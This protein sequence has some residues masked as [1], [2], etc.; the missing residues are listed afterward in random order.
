MESLILRAQVPDNPYTYPK[1]VLKSLLQTPSNKLLG[2]WTDRLG[3]TTICGCGCDL[4]QGSFG[5]KGEGYR[6]SYC[7]QLPLLIASSSCFW[8]WLN[9]KHCFCSSLS[10]NNRGLIWNL[11]VTRLHMLGETTSNSTQ[12]CV[13]ISKATGSLGR[14]YD[15]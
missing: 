5:A 8:S 15:S 14:K 1:P 13:S 6:G 10:R 7:Y 11:L 4:F 9:H 2:T 3:H 12:I